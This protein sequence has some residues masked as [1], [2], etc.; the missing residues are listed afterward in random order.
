MMLSGQSRK[1]LMAEA[2]FEQ[3]LWREV[4]WLNDENEPTP[5]AIVSAQ[6]RDRAAALGALSTGVLSTSSSD[7][8]PTLLAVV[9]RVAGVAPP[10]S[11]RAQK[12]ALHEDEWV[13]V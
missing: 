3:R 5:C 8:S 9:A 13:L 10:K 6:L 11:E 12:G 2:A 7:L 1:N 4:C